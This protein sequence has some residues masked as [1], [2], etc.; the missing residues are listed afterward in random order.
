MNT[1]TTPALGGSYIRQDDGELTLKHRTKDERT[2]PPATE[3]DTPERE[4]GRAQESVA[5]A[6]AT[7]RDT[8]MAEGHAS[9][10]S[11]KTKQKR[12]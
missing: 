12:G 10:A 1:P 8:D 2:A 4:R 3:H 5:D 6:A 11:S 9:L 7:A